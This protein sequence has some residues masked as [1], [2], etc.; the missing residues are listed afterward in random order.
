MLIK[1]PS[2]SWNSETCRHLY[3]LVWIVMCGDWKW[4]WWAHMFS[5]HC[6]RGHYAGQTE[7]ATFYNYLFRLCIIVYLQNGSFLPIENIFYEQVD[8]GSLLQNVWYFGGGCFSDIRRD[9][10]WTWSDLISD[11]V[12]GTGGWCCVGK[13]EFRLGCAIWFTHWNPFGSPWKILKAYG[14]SWNPLEDISI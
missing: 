4:W 12:L 1:W 14:S 7:A 5:I 10:T 13:L 6:W 9:W 2:I 8:L 3:F 11:Q